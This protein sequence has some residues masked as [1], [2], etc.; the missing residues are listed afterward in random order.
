VPD[1]GKSTVDIWASSIGT[2]LDRGEGS[3]RRGDRW[4]APCVEASFVTGVE[5]SCDRHRSFVC[6]RCRSF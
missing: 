5:A 4:I 2:P 6:D 3:I 1:L